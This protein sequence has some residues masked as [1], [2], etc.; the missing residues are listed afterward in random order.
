MTTNPLTADLLLRSVEEWNTTRR[1]NPGVSPDLTDAYLTDAYLTRANLS[2]ADLTGANLTGA[3]LTGASLTGASLTGADLTGAS[4]T[5]AN[6]TGAD[7]T[8]AYLTDAY[9]SGATLNWTSHDLLSEVLRRAA[10]DNA[11]KLML[12][13][14]PLVTRDK[15]WHNYAAMDIP[16]DLRAW[17]IAILR[18]YIR[19][20]DGHPALLDEEVAL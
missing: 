14:L 20:G 17:A 1:V 18:A 16:V 7:L 11:R 19:P 6:L 5:D 3:D 9:L 12:A 2:R 4:L 10:G 13:G 8:G 15:C